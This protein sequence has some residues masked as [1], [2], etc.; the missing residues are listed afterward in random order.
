MVLMQKVEK[1]LGSSSLKTYRGY[2]RQV[3]A[4]S[5]GKGRHLAQPKGGGYVTAS[6]MIAWLGIWKVQGHILMMV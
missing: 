5:G 3:K 6:R 2:Q 4:P 1:E